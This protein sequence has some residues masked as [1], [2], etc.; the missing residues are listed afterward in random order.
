MHRVCF[1]LPNGLTQAHL[2]LDV[3]GSDNAGKTTSDYQP[4]AL[5]TRIKGVLKD[6][7]WRSSILNMMRT[8]S[9]CSHAMAAWRPVAPDAAAQ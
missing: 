5:W 9:P 4:G 7:T 3:D 8:L 2:F 1:Y 6:C